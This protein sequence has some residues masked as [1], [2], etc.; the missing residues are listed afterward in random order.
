VRVIP[1]SNPFAES[2]EGQMLLEKCKT[3][4]KTPSEI[5]NLSGADDTFLTYAI[6][7]KYERK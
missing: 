5:L 4:G 2:N 6:S 3:L 7:K 1:A